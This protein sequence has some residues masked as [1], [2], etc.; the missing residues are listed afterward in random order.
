MLEPK[1]GKKPG[2]L[3]V[4]LLSKK[5]GDDE[6]APPGAEKGMPD[7]AMPEPEPEDPEQ[8]EG[9]AL[10][11]RA[12]DAA[13]SDDPK[14]FYEAITGLMNHHLAKDDKEEPDDGPILPSGDDEE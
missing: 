3:I 14:S 6:K 9:E 8:H 7:K 10:A 2:G 4:S 1:D 12:L 11:S 5:D 13:K